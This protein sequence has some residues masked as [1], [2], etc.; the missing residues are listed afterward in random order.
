MLEATGEM[1]YDFSPARPP[2]MEL[3]EGLSVLMEE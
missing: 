1:P 2:C 3:P